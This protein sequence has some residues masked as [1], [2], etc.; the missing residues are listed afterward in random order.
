MRFNNLVVCDEAFVEAELIIDGK[1]IFIEGELVCQWF[2]VDA[3]WMADG[4]AASAIAL[5]NSDANG[6]RI[7]E[8]IAAA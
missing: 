3:A 2:H 7:R 4:S 8:I 6:A 1:K 5:D